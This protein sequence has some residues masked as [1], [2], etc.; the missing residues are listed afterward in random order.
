MEQKLAS[1]DCT[2]S[3]PGPTT[4]Q[5]SKKKIAHWDSHSF[6]QI[7]C[8]PKCPFSRS[9][10]TR[11]PASPAGQ[12]FD[13]MPAPHP[14]AHPSLFARVWYWEQPSISQ[15]IYLEGRRA[16][17]LHAASDIYSFRKT[18]PLLVLSPSLSNF[19]APQV[20]CQTN[21]LSLNP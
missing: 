9:N 15:G 18:C 19:I 10:S 6:K 17:L 12:G 14:R 21:D 5:D 3:G 7:E 2:C 13:T 20:A 11:H 16:G 4:A 8:H 1:L